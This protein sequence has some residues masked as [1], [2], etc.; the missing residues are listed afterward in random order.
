MV[1]KVIIVIAVIDIA[2]MVYS[3]ATA[4]YMDEPKEDDFIDYKNEKNNEGLINDK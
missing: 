1:L 4:P 2:F 3:Y